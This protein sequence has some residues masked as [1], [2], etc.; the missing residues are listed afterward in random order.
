MATSK[1]WIRTDAD[2]RAVKDGCHFDEAAALKVRKFFREILRHSKGTDFSGKPFDLLDWQWEEFIGPLFGWK[3]KDGTRRYR[4]ASIWISKKN[5]K[6]TLCSGLVLFGLIADGEPGAEIYG[7]AADR[8]QAGIVFNEAASM[9]Y[10]SPELKSRLQVIESTKR[11]VFPQTR[12]FYTVLSKDARK[13]GHG[14]NGHLMVIDELHVVN[15]ELYDTLRYAGAARKQPLLIEISTAGN[16]KESLGYD[17][18]LYAKSVHEGR[19]EDDQLLTY[20]AEADLN[21]VWADEKQWRKANPSLGHTITLE[22]FRADWKEASQGSTA[23]KSNFCQLRLNIWQDAVHAWLDMEKWDACNEPIDLEALKGQPCYVGLDLASTTDTACMVLLFPQEESKYSVL[24]FCWVPE[25]ACRR[26]ERKNKT[27]LDNW[28]RDGHVDKTSGDVIDYSA[29]HAKINELADVYDMRVIGVDPWNAT[30]LA[31]QLM[32]DGFTVENVRQGY[33]SMSAPAKELEGLVLQ[34]RLRHGGNPVLRWMAGNVSAE[35]D[36][37]GNIKPSKK[38][39]SEKIDGIVALIMA[40]GLAMQ[41]EP[42]DKV[43]VEAW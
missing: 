7:A 9:V 20:I 1:K 3:R 4:R 24:L 27:L 19:A 39:S 26:R 34:G 8:N 22:S 10:Q 2:K 12:S 18:Y 37:A 43:T 31:T 5:G 21:D 40:L 41:A 16:D 28:A 42:T 13:T 33:S 6:S 32:A 30:H 38:T 29:I 36:P 15:Q 23:A 25:E 11:I 35:I 14:V 17:R